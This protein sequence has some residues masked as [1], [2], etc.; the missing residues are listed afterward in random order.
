MGEAT[1]KKHRQRGIVATGEVA[2]ELIPLNGDYLALRNDEL[3]WSL[4]VVWRSMVGRQ[5][6][7]KHNDFSQ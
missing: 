5:D 7:A 6:V 1:F 4:S 2:F 3:P